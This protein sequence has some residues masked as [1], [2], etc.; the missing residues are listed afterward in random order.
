MTARTTVTHTITTTAGGVHRRTLLAEVSIRPV[1][2][3]WLVT[4]RYGPLSRTR[5]RPTWRTT[6]A[7]F[8]Q[9]AARAQRFVE[10]VNHFPDSEPAKEPR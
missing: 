10:H 8:E 1:L 3:G 4:E 7:V 9:A 2:L 5:W 6:V